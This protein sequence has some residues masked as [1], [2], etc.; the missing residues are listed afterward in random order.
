MH[1]T[2]Q[3]IVGVIKHDIKKDRFMEKT[4]INVRLV[5]DNR[6]NISMF[7]P[8]YGHRI[9][10][11]SKIPCVLDFNAQLRNAQENNGLVT[12]RT[13]YRYKIIPIDIVGLDLD[14]DVDG[15][16]V[17]VINKGRIDENGDSIEIRCPI[18]SNKFTKDVSVETVSDVLNKKDTT[19]VYFANARKLVEVLNPSNDNEISRI[20]K[21]VTD[22]NKMKEMIKQTRDYN[23]SSVNEYFKQL[24]KDKETVKINVSVES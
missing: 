2:L 23:I 6:V 9:Y 14:K 8:L 16:N 12:N 20:E 15:S 3:S 24:D 21:L 22:L 13:P 5:E 19:S 11:A 17:I 10:K 18:D 1:N 4:S 7:G